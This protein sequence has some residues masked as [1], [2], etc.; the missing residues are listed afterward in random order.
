VLRKHFLNVF[1]LI[2]VIIRYGT[3][4]I[5]I[6]GYRKMPF[7]KHR[8]SFVTLSEGTLLQSCTLQ[9]RF[10]TT[11]QDGLNLP[12][13]SFGCVT[14]VRPLENKNIRVDLDLANH[15]AARRFAEARLFSGACHV[16]LI[17]N[18]AK[19]RPAGWAIAA[20]RLLAATG[21]AD[22]NYGVLLKHGTV[23]V[24]LAPGEHGVL[25][26]LMRSIEKGTLER[27]IP[28]AIRNPT[29]H[30]SASAVA[31]SPTSLFG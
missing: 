16:R 30:R 9:I 22:T 12:L 11:F 1:E 17:P 21:I 15:R 28:V 20:R 13:D 31:Y 23:G 4:T 8:S 26:V 14:A 27:I 25:G 3:K 19:T 18:R 5:L 7:L 24:S 6:P 10:E 29:P 2:S